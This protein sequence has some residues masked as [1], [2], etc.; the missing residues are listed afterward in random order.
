MRHENLCR[1]HHYKFDIKVF[2]RIGNLILYQNMRSWIQ[3]LSLSLYLLFKFLCVG[4]HILKD[5]FSL[6]VRWVFELCG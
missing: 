1:Y 2:G 5:N 6:H 4:S 3:T